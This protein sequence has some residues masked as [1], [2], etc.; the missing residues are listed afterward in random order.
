V[1]ESSFC[2]D[3]KYSNAWSSHNMV[4]SLPLGRIGRMMVVFTGDGATYGQ[5]MALGTIYVWFAWHTP[6]TIFGFCARHHWAPQLS[7]GRRQ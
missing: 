7:Y 3:H 6:R 5:M 1:V 4:Q 2:C